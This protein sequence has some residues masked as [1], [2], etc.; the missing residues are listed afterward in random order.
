VA[1]SAPFCL[2]GQPSQLGDEMEMGEA[3]LGFLVLYD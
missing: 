2:V 1:H 3:P